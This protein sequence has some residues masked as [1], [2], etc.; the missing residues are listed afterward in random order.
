M[1]KVLPYCPYTPRDELLE[2]VFSMD[3]T[4][5][6]YEL[7]RTLE[8]FRTLKVT[9]HPALGYLTVRFKDAKHYIRIKKR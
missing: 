3:S 2:I 7:K 6:P 9:I 5:K 1:E 8:R 4:R